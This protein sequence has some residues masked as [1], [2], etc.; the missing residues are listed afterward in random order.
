[1][2]IKMPNFAYATKIFT[3]IVSA[4]HAQC[5]VLMLIVHAFSAIGFVYVDISICR[6]WCTY[7]ELI[8]QSFGMNAMNVQGVEKEMSG[9]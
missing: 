4:V 6:I 1:M 5:Q 3:T 7:K 9:K 8:G 2:M